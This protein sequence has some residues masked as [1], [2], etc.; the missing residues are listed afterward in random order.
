MMKKWTWPV[1]EPFDVN[2]EVTAFAGAG[3]DDVLPGRAGAGGG[4]VARREAI[5]SA[6]AP[7]EDRAVSPG[8]RPS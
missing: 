7:S 3:R 8:R 2:G 4:P 5:T 6:P 1:Y